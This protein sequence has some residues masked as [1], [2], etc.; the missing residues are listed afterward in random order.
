MTGLVARHRPNHPDDD[1]TQPGVLFRVV[2]D[3]SAKKATIENAADHM[4]VVPRDIQ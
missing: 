2:M 4:K 3:E 1:F